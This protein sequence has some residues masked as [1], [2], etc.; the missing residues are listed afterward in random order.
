[1][2][3]KK[4]RSQTSNRKL[5]AGETD[6]ICE[7]E[8]KL[9]GSRGRRRKT[10]TNSSRNI[11]SLEE[12]T[13]TDDVQK[14]KAVKFRSSGTWFKTSSHLISLFWW[15]CVCMFADR[16]CQVHDLIWWKLNWIPWRHSFRLAWDGQ[17]LPPADCG[18]TRPWLFQQ[19]DSAQPSAA[20][21]TGSSLR[22]ACDTPSSGRRTLSRSRTPWPRRP[23]CSTPSTW[24]SSSWS[25]SHW[26][27]TRGCPS[28]CARN[29]TPSSTSATASW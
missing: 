25:G 14:P 8:T 29:A 17:V 18:E 24:T 11:S 12:A 28:L 16:L 21:A 1:M 20:C 3:K 10:A 22:A 4:G 9:P 2:M 19:A 5:T 13:A 15:W 26:I 6:K 27:G 7:K 23:F